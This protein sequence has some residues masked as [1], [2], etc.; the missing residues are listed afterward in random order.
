MNTEERIARHTAEQSLADFF[1]SQVGNLPFYDCPECK[2]KGGTIVVKYVKSH[3]DYLPFWRE[4]ACMKIRR[5]RQKGMQSGLGGAQENKTFDSYN[6]ADIWQANVKKAAMEYI[7]E[8]KAWFYIGGQSGAGKT[9]ICTAIA[10]ECLKRGQT[11]RYMVWREAGTRLKRLVSFKSDDYESEIE[12][13]K[14]VEVLYID[15]LFK[16]RRRNNELSV[17]DGDVNP[18]FEILNYRYNKGSKTII[19]CEL[20]LNELTEIDEAIAGRIFEKTLKNKYFVYIRK[21]DTRNYRM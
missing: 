18:A 14:N 6:T 19:S 20:S 1:N 17:T 12:K 8:P 15:D 2:N 10:A 9:H 4:C 13:Y 21:D 3:D 7:N 11:V 5:A 16:S